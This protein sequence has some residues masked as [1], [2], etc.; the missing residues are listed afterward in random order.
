MRLLNLF[1]TSSIRRRISSAFL[2]ITAVVITLV[3]ASYFQL[4]QVKPSS[5]IIIE[6]SDELVALQRL[7][8]S[9][10]ALDVNM[11]RYLTIRG[12][13]YRE[14]VQKNLQEI[15]DVVA[16]LQDDANSTTEIQKTVA[17]LETVATDLQTKVDLVFAT[18]DSSSSADINRSV[19]GVYQTIDQV[20]ELQQE[21]SARTLTYL[22]STAQAQG[23]VASKVLTQSIVL[24]IIV[25]M[26]AVITTITMDRRLRTISSLTET[27]VAISS[28]DLS[29]VAPVES[30]DE[31]GTLAKS[32]NVMTSQLRDLID[33][34]EHR[35]A[36]RTKALS[37][38]A[39]VSTAASTN[40]DTDK[41]LQQVVDLAKE[42]F[43]FYHA[44]IYLLNEAGDTLVLSS[45]AG[46]IGRMMVA[47]KRSIPLDGEQSLVARAAR[48]RKGVTVNDVTTAPDFLPNPLLPDTHAELAVPMMVG[49]KVIGVFDVQSEIAGRFTDADIAV[50]TTLASQVAA[51]VQNARSYTEMQSN[52]AQLTEALN[53]S[54]LANWEYDLEH[55]LFTFNDQFYSIFRT[56][57]EKAGGYKLSSADYARLFVHPED[58][59][60]VGLEIQKTIDNKDRRYSAALEHRIIFSDGEIGYIAV[61]ITVER[62][63]NGKVTR[64]YGANQDITERRRLEEANR[65]RA[66]HQEAINTITQKIQS[67]TT[68]ESALQI[69]ARELGHTL[70]KRQTLVTLEPSALGGNGKE[71]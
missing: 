66:F 16:D 60:L 22:Q 42:R 48:M 33:S 38:V 65:K 17:E 61:R 47:E 56:T 49:D 43:G 41:L 11:E 30:N 7:S 37:S 70:G 2:L 62:D 19:I 32:F 52:R 50:Q 69:A 59:P 12:V 64:W 63:E 55:D 40:L 14:D 23:L 5:D 24:G 46:E 20:K 28:G 1:G 34:L 15:A 35:V 68:I 45:G 31:I 9:I 13:T 26:I 3:A 53:I 54:R 71:E 67:A 6:D 39:D 29:R 25:T 36:D 51:A 10:S 58:A 8:V 18:L 4:Q 21:L 57:A 27:A 44:H